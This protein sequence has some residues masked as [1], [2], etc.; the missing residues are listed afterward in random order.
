MKPK[1]PKN[2]VVGLNY[3]SHEDEFPVIMKEII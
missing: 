1:K 3:F 2:T